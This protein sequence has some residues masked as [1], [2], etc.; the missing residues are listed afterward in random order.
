MNFGTG[1]FTIEAWVYPNSLSSDWFIITASGS[2]G[3]FFGYSSTTTLGYGW[4][5][6]GTAWDYRVASTAT[7]GAWQHVAVTRSGTSMRLFVNGTQAGTTQTISTAYDMSTTSTTVGSQGA[8][9]YLNGYIDDLRV[10]K[11]FA[12][13]TG[14]FTPSTTTFITQ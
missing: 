7:T 12:R 6:A 8:N 4:G 10:T 1:D 9:Y 2:G 3:F 13:Y 5:R 11:G 14:N